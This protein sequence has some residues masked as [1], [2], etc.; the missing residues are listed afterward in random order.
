MAYFSKARKE[1]LVINAIY[2]II[3]FITLSAGL[4]FW[5]R[6]VTYQE[7][8]IIDQTEM[9][10]LSAK[11]IEIYVLHELVQ[12]SLVYAVASKEVHPAMYQ[13]TLRKKDSI[14]S[15]LNAALKSQGF[16]KSGLDIIKSMIDKYVIQCKQFVETSGDSASDGSIEFQSKKEYD[17][18]I[19]EIEVFENVLEDNAKSDYEW[20]IVDNAIIQIILVLL[21]LPILFIASHN[22][23]SEIKSRESLLR[24]LED[25]N[26]RY[27]FH[28]GEATA[29]N[30]D[31]VV[32]KSIDSFQRAF[33]FVEKISSGNY[34]EA[35]TLLPEST[36]PLNQN[37]LMGALSDMSEKLKKSEDEDIERQWVSSG[38]NEFYGVVRN[39]QDKPDLLVEKANT[40]LTKYLAS[41]QGGL[42]VL[43]KSEEKEFLELA[44]CYAFNKKKWIEKK[45]DI[46]DSLVGQ[47]FLEGE[48]VLLTE[49]PAGYTSITSG[50]GDA[51]PTC[52]LIVP[53][54]YNEKTEAVFEVARFKKYLPFEI[55]FVKK[56]GEFLAAALQ[57]AASN[58]KMQQI[59][60]ESVER[61]EELRAQEEELRQNMEELEAT[62]EA[63][64]RHEKAL[65]AP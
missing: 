1:K 2:L 54:I 42:F 5:N 29:I 41:Q 6:H 62:N 18:I 7:R 64:K 51:T 17:A 20:S 56:S 38:L 33:N 50:L 52:L 43:R 45:I 61:A 3:G 26:K 48:H 19:H 8:G 16:K 32:K 53:L 49:I 57:T 40:F 24:N 4:S 31:A 15:Q 60:Q 39:F 65:T 34:A 14:F 35:K 44:A 36:R 12:T 21:S 46:G 13:T 11:N 37:T 55:E 28:D 47:A 10:K 30:A 63:M 58:F 25:N 27:L 59:L 23:K 9:V 22:L